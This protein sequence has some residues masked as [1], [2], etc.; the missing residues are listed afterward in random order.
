MADYY[1]FCDQ[2]DI[3]DEDKLQ[4]A[5]DTLD[6]YDKNL[7]LLYHCAHRAINK[8]DKI[9]YKC[10][11]KKYSTPPKELALTDVFTVNRTYGNTCVFN[12]VARNYFLKYEMGEIR[13][14]DWTINII[15]SALGRVIF[16]NTP[17]ISYRLHEANCFG[18]TNLNLITIK[19]FLKYL[20]NYEFNNTRLKEMQ[21]LKKR[22]YEYLPQNNKEFVDLLCNYKNDK[23]AKKAL[24]KYKPYFSHKHLFI[25]IYNKFLIRTK[26]L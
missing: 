25:K 12:S 18:P 9:I 26:K 6:C 15:C 23:K 8:D 24:L 19:K 11:H 14:H 20:K 2:D 22:L 3:W 13:F 4:V 1:A 7:P 17:H 5:V 16:D 10:S 21:L